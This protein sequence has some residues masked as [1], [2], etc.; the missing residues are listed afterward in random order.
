MA[1]S[2]ERRQGAPGVLCVKDPGLTIHCYKTDQYDREVCS[3]H[4]DRG[5]LGA[6]LVGAGLT[7]HFK[8]FQDEPTTVERSLYLQ[9]E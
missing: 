9:L 3:V 8:Q 4:T 6:S 2:L 7:W 5:D 1:G